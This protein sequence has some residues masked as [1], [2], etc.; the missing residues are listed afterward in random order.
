MIDLHYGQS[1][2]FSDLFVERNHRYHAVNCTR[3]WGKSHLAGSAAIT[4]GLE[5][6][7]I[8]AWVPNKNVY[9]IAPTF[10]QV[11]DVYFPMMMFQFG[12]DVWCPDASKQMGVIKLPNNTEIRMLSYESIERMRGK[13]AFFVVWDE[14][15]S[16]YKG[17]KPKDAWES[18]I[19]PCIVTRWSPKQAA[20]FGVS[21]GRAL[22]ISTPKGYNYFHELCMSHETDPDWAYSHFD[23]TQ[24]PRL[25]VDEIEK[26][27]E[28]TDPIKFASE[29]LAAFKESGANVFYPFDRKIHVRSCDYFQENE[30]VHAAIDFNVGKQHTSFGAIRGGQIQWLDEM[31][32]HPD[33]EQLAAAI[34][35]RFGDRKVLAFPDPTGKSRKTSA[36][37]GRTDFTILQSAGI[38]VLARNSSPGIVDS[39][40]CVNRLLQNAN[41]RVSMYFDPKVKDLITSMERTVWLDNNA[42]TATLDKKDGWEHASDAIRYFSE[43]MFP[44]NGT[45]RVSQSRNY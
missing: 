40:N 20:E 1:G 26:I 43:Y 36:K 28:N 15:S 2:V 9:L 12:L 41:G 21:P 16:C 44:I 4:A 34:R 35:G 23:Y 33:T 25:D 13:G 39:V 6:Q 18:I 19:K 38:E 22:I 14:V 3:G 27:K 30:I 10:D 37:V 45:P 31:S 5:L 32:G 42:N 8:P 7:E 11:V 17:T 29:Y 24:A